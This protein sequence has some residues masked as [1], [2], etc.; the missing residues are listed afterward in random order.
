MLID[1]AQETHCF[2][3]VPVLNERPQALRL[4]TI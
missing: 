4:V 1:S 2:G 3:Q